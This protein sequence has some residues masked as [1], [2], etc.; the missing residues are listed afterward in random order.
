[1]LEVKY[2]AGRELA[3]RFADGLSGIL[4]IDRSFCTGV[5]E[6]L[7]NDNLVSCAKVDNGALN[8]TGEQNRDRP[9]FIFCLFL[10]MGLNELT[11][12]HH[13]WQSADLSVPALIE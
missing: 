11:C 8:K 2:I 3:I 4:H 9:L 5:F 10:L 1:V 13:R 7:Q 12:Y 6:P